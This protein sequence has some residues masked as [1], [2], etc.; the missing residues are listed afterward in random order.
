MEDVQRHLQSARRTAVLPVLIYV[1][2]ALAAPLVPWYFFFFFWFCCFYFYLCNSSSCSLHGSLHPSQLLSSLQSIPR[3]SLALPMASKLLV[4]FFYKSSPSFLF[5][6]F[7][8]FFFFLFF[9]FFFFFL[10]SFRNHLPFHIHCRPRCDRHARDRQHPPGFRC[11]LDSHP[12]RV[13]E[14]RGFNGLLHCLYHVCEKDRT[15]K[16]RGGR[17]G[18]VILIYYYLGRSLVLLSDTV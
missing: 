12:L 17:E 15:T 14:Q 7:S 6:L 18:E 11:S 4:S 13:R 9:L 2:I 10:I 5:F 3:K 8:F 1:L 16:E